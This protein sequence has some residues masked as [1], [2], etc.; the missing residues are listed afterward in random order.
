M[1]SSAEG[2]QEANARIAGLQV[3][4]EQNAK[5]LEERMRYLLDGYEYMESVASQVSVC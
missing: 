4:T 2:L 3:S 5:V 1:L